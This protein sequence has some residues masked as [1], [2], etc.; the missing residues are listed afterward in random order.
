MADARGVC[1][2]RSPTVVASVP[3]LVGR[4]EA[5]R[6]PVRHW[7]QSQEGLSQVALGGS[8]RCVPE[9]TPC[10]IPSRFSWLGL[11]DVD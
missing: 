8:G 7:E 1:R 2:A 11:V 5:M 3:G 10:G 9:N 6:W 4:D